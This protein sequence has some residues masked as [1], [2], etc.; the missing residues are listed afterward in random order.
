MPR[1]HLT[2]CNNSIIDS[3]RIL[4]QTDIAKPK[5]SIKAITKEKPG[6]V[7]DKKINCSLGKIKLSSN[8][9]SIGA[10]EQDISA[11]KD[12]ANIE[13]EEASNRQLKK[14]LMKNKNQSGNEILIIE[15]TEENSNEKIADEIAN[16]IIQS[17]IYSEI[18]KEDI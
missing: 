16:E 17:L 5:V 9:L 14:E 4:N 6:K 13:W 11:D 2:L 12:K 1:F 10:F 7:L 15:R 18:L 3:N 8:T